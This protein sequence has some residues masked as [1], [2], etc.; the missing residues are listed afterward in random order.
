MHLLYHL[1]T[2]VF[3][4]AVGDVS[5]KELDRQLVLCVRDLYVARLP[6]PTL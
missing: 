6:A 4:F 5:I 1:D 3:G 2:F